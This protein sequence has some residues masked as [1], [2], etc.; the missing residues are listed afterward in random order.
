MFLRFSGGSLLGTFWIRFG[1]VWVHFWSVLGP[2]TLGLITLGLITL[3]SVRDH[4]EVITLGPLWVY[5]GSLS[6]CF[7][8]F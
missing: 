7:R 8:S 5:F 3:G 2:I 6:V 4:V 1:S